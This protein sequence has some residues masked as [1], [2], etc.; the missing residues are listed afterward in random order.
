MRE[1]FQDIQSEVRGAWRFRWLAMGI[2]WAGC[3]LGWILVFMMPD[4]YAAEARFYV[5]TSTRLDEVMGGVIIDSDEGSQLAL[6]RQAMLSRPVLEEVARQADLDLRARTPQEKEDLIAGLRRAVKIESQSTR[7]NSDDGIYLISFRDG[8]RD[9]SLAVV[10]AMLETF[11]KDFV[12]GQTVGSDETVRFLERK[13]TDY[14]EQLKEREQALAIFKRQNVGLLP[15]E[16]GGYFERMQAAMA[17]LEALEGELGVAASRQSALR[18]QLARERPFLDGDGDE[19]GAIT[20][21][22]NEL[23][24]RIVELEESLQDFLLRYTDKHPDVI[25][26]RT[27]LDQLYERRRRENEALV[28]DGGLEGVPL[29]DNPVYQE[30]QISLNETNVEVSTLQGQVN[31]QRARVAELQA[32]VDVIP[33]I[34]AQLAEL[35]RD[36]D[37]MRSVYA[38]LRERLEQERIRKSR[39]GW[40]GVNFQI[41]DPPVA[42]FEPVAPDRPKLLIFV[43]FA[44]LAAGAGGAYLVH[45]V[46]PVFVEPR[47]LMEATGLPVL[48]TVSLT[49]LERHRAQRR[50]EAGSLAVVCIALVIA[51]VLV[52]TFQEAGVEAGAKLRRMAAL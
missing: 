20:T 33:V 47:A 38:E 46:K 25:A 42:S 32:K 9:K 45:Q 26:I 18:A 7:R 13:I 49:W 37:Q 4:Q 22:R 23:E 16:S 41:I 48:G 19:E 5:N 34:E 28:G 40:E 50:F 44:A 52:L 35:T 15:G 12:T 1:V 3:V 21:P 17:D 6:V 51:L 11:K 30:V 29:A 10:D 8:R 24:S 31:T 2:A 43:L 14:Q 39:I 27:Q 36:Y